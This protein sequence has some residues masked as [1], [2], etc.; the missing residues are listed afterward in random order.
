AAP[1]AL[2]D[3]ADARIV[4]RGTG[5]TVVCVPVDGDLLAVKLFDESSLLDRLEGM[6]VGSGA[7]RVARAMRL[8]P[9][10]RLRAPGLVAWVEAGRGVTRRASCGVSE[11]VSGAQLHEAWATLTVAER[12]RFARALGVYMRSLHAA[13]LYPQ[14]TGSGN[15]LALRDETT[16]QF[17][18]V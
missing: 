6:F 10:A 13:G 7:Q 14:D 5:R 1:E 8:M 2:L 18:L 3:C 16:W 12:H 9:D 11:W 4:N 17:V 15:I